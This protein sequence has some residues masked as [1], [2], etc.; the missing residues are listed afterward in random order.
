MN[1]HKRLCFSYTAP[2][3]CQTLKRVN[4]MPLTVKISLQPKFRCVAARREHGKKRRAWEGMGPP[5]S[6]APVPSSLRKPH[7]VALFQ[8]ALQS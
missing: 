7:C 1:L 2:T 8:T 6:L 5:G 3:V 4:P